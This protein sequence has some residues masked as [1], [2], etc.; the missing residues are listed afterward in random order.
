MNS[1]SSYPARELFNC[2]WV[3]EHIVDADTITLY[4]YILK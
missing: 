1:G 4:S 2:R 3:T